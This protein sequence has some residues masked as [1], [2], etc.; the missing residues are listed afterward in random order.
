MKV[1]VIQIKTYNTRKGWFGNYTLVVK[2]RSV[3]KCYYSQGY[4]KNEK[5]KKDIDFS[6]TVPEKVCKEILHDYCIDSKDL[7]N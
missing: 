4:Q 5:C 6:F 3:E 7:I 2:G 1:S